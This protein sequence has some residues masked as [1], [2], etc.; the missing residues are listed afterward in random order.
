VTE[1]QPDQILA[2]LERHR[3]RYVVIGGLAAALH[4]APYV[5]VDIDV[6][7]DQ[8]HDNMRRLSEALRDLKARIRT[9]AVPEGVAFDHSGESLSSAFLL[10]TVTRFGDLDL[11]MIPAGTGGYRD[12]I[13]NALAIEIKGI[14]IK[15]ASLEDVIRS[16]EAA[17]R[18]QDHLALPLLRQTLE[19]IKRR[20]QT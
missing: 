14:T 16:K 12:L 1:F 13:R 11:S 17:G 3:V 8:E 5:T 6:T 7:P 10:N 19:E 4:G 18:P 9:E 20:R 15:V 2:V